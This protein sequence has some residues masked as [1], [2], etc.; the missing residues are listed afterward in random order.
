VR[1]LTLAL[2]LAGYA[3]VFVRVPSPGAGRRFDPLD[4]RGRQVEQA[5]ESHDFTRALPVALDL[6]AAYP[7]DAVIAYWL[8]EIYTGLGRAAD[9]DAS[10]HRYQAAT[11]GS[12]DEG[13]P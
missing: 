5:I 8:T 1:R 4:P 2:L 11:G 10:W 9:A 3:L 12:D 13:R 6:D 7:G